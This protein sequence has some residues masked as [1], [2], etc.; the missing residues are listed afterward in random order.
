[1]AASLEELG[2]RVSFGAAAPEA[3][4]PGV[5]YYVPVGFGTP[6]YEGDIDGRDGERAWDVYSRKFSEGL[7]EAQ[8]GGK[9]VRIGTAC[10]DGTYG[11]FPG[12]S[13]SCHPGT[14]CS[15]V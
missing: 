11:F 3:L 14:F 7:R 2:I 10:L 5:P 12:S 9:L 6:P 4:W 15:K 13:F 1:M 8:V